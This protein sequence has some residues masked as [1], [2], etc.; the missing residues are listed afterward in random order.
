MKVFLII[1]L[2][3][4]VLIFLICLSGVVISFSYWGGV[5]EW[6]VKYLGIK[7]LPRKKKPE[8]S[9]GDSAKPKKKKKKKGKKE[10][11]KPDSD[12]EEE[13]KPKEKRKDFLFDKIVKIEQR[14]VK[15][16]D[17]G[18]NALAAL[19]PSFPHLLK[20]VRWYRIETDILVGGED[21]GECARLYGEIQA[22]LQTI[23][24]MAEHWIKVNRKSVLVECDFTEDSTRWNVRF[25]VRI[26][27][28]A[29]IRMGISFLWHFLKDRKETKK[30]IV[31]E[32]V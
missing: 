26:R 27:M 5:L 30:L 29:L 3:L 12:S 28:G 6:N 7:L 11:S 2:I 4:A 22:I 24:E 21:A 1:L 9:S 18:G 15:Y 31:S 14:L 20:G 23:I 32:K 13:N 17:L 25:C 8:N 19:A 10:D 16:T